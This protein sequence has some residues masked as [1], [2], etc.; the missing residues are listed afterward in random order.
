VK[1]AKVRPSADASRQVLDLGRR[2]VLDS[3]P[4]PEPVAS[5]PPAGG[6]AVRAGST[7]AA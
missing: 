1:F 4:M 5:P 7:E 3:V 2:V 6:V